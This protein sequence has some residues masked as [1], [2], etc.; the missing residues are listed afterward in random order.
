MKRIVIAIVLF[1]SMLYANAPI[2]VGIKPSEPWVM[3]DDTQQPKGFS[4]DLIRQIANDLNRSIEWVYLESVNDIIQRAK[5]HQIDVGISAIT[6]NSK[7]EEVVDFSH[8]MYELGLQIMV[9]SKDVQLNPLGTLMEQVEKLFSLSGF[10]N[11]LVI[12]FV[13]INIRWYLNIHSKKEEIIFDQ[14]YFKGIYESFWWALT[15]LITWEAPKSKGFSRVLDLSWHV[16]GLLGFSLL[17]AMVTSSLTA[18]AVG[19]SIKN[20]KDLIG[21]YVAAV[22]TDAPREYLE[23][24][25]ANVVAVK[26]LE[27][28]IELVRKGEVK[29][30]VHD[31]PRLIYLANKINTKL[32]RKELVVL[33]HIFNHQ[34]Y[35][36]VFPE[37]STIREDVNRELLKLRTPQGAQESYYDTLNQKWFKQP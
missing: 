3:Y 25:G 36:I 9:S 1:C 5:T 17:T 26:S 18:K 23:N 21:K 33:P 14:R 27:D 11:F 28:G 24:L 16:M 12:I 2:K 8:S 32:Q 6:I 30:L 37:N 31:G 7:R 34:N 15:M 22:A 10:L 13:M 4:I 19:G 20:E 29:A 35:G